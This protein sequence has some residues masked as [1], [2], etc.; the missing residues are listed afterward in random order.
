MMYLAILIV[1]AL[2]IIVTSFLLGFTHVKRDP[3][4]HKLF[5]VIWPIAS[6]IIG[7]IMFAVFSFNW[8][9]NAGDVLNTKFKAYLEA[10]KP[11]NKVKAY[12]K[13]Q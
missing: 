11:I 1:Y 8:A 6:P 4:L 9:F 7:F 3:D 5:S 13:I 12:L 10:R 2:G